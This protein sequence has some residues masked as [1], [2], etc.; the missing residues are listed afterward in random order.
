MKS[1][2]PYSKDHPNTHVAAT[3]GSLGSAVVEA[4]PLETDPLQFWTA[5]PTHPT[6]VDLRIFRDGKLVP[7]K[8]RC[9]R[10]NGPFQGRP[11]LIAQLA[12]TL[13]ILLQHAAP[14]TVRQRLQGLRAWWRLFD[15][16]ERDAQRAG[17]PIRS[18]NNVAGIT[19][20][21]RQ[22]AVD[23]HMASRAFSN[24]VQLL[25]LVRQ[26]EH[27]PPLHWQG[28]IDATPIRTLPPLEQIRQVRIA[29][30][31][32]WFA[33]L[34]RWE[35]ADQLL[36]GDPPISEAERELLNNY[37][38]FRHYVLQSRHPLPSAPTVRGELSKFQFSRRGLN[39][40]DMLRGF[41]P[42]SNDVRI[43]FH[44]CLAYTGWNPSVLLS[45]DVDSSIIEPHPKDPSRYL[46]V[47]NKSRGQRTVVS[48]GL[49]KSRSSAGMIIRALIERTAPLR[50]H[51]RREVVLAEQRCAD[52][53]TRGATPQDRNTAY[54]QWVRLK[55]AVRTPWLCTAPKR[56]EIAWL[57]QLNY[58]F[59]NTIRAPYSFLGQLI[60]DLNTKL[61]PDRQ[62]APFT[63]SDFRDAFAAYAYDVSGGM[64]LYVMRMLGHA[65]P[66][67]TQRYLD[68]SLL[69]ARRNWQ[70]LTFSSALWREVKHHGAVDPT[71]IAKW[72]RDGQ[73]TDTER[74]RLQTYRALQR[75][76]IGVGCRDPSHPPKSIAPDFVH[77]GIALCPVQRC[78]LCVEHAVIFPDSLPGLAM[79]MAELSFIRT[80]MSMTAFMESTFGQEISN[81]QLALSYFEKDKV[82]SHLRY[83]EQ[84][85]ANGTHRVIDH[86]GSAST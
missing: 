21:H 30:K 59:S 46:M 13:A 80:H 35:R 57:T 29:L 56:Q 14:P 23:D 62:I 49:Y 43:A 70:Y 39:R 26:A 5:H 19:N 2:R 51:L 86:D 4:P 68:N 50:D 52:L 17:T 53:L 81:T 84:Q 31:H 3:D 15:A 71:V 10:W 41:Y 60:H 61:P 77:D 74:L 65:R 33:T 8:H 63:A 69:N 82:E 76:R 28:P 25:N 48:E 9:A 16:V 45:L 6:H 22:R 72:T 38:R 78:T 55:Q 7:Q 75:S 79:R 32:A 34:N 1:I 64:A 83:W 24:F 73:V 67:T 54:R 42:D 20:L 47:A 44:L 85:I 36:N 12:P 58:A 18:V 37:Q 11:Q 40:V 66:D 27:L